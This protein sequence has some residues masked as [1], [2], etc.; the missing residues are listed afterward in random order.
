MFF[1]F[2]HPPKPP[3]LKLFLPSLLSPFLSLFD[4]GRGGFLSASAREWK[5]SLC[6]CA[7]FARFFPTLA[8]VVVVF[9]SGSGSGKT[10]ERYEKKKKTAAAKK[11][12]DT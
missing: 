2:P 4:S 9:G 3:L 8:G 10:T 6:V 11:S 12:F 5:R 1:L 7:F